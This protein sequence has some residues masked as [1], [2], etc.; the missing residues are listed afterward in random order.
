MLAGAVALLLVFAG[1]GESGDPTSF[2]D[3]EIWENVRSG[4]IESGDEDLGPQIEADLLAVCECAYAEASTTSPFDE[5][6]GE[7]DR[8][9]SDI[10]DISDSLLM[11]VRQCIL[12]EAG[13]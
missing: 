5:F 1:C 10:D 3:P 13:F 6:V 4:C 9:R 11:I 2:D 12:D 8:F 7:D